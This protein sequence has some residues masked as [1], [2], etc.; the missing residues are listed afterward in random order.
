MS[1]AST[2][3]RAVLLGA[4]CAACTP[5]FV[6]ARTLESKTPGYVS[7]HADTRL[8]YFGKPGLNYCAEPMPDALREKTLR[9][10]A[11]R[12]HKG[13]V[14]IKA[15]D[16]AD[17]SVST[18]DAA[19]AELQTSLI[20]KELAG[21]DS[22]VL[23]SRELMYRL[24]ELNLN[25]SGKDDPSE[26]ELDRFNRTIDAYTKIAGA[27]AD[28]A[29]ADKAEAEATRALIDGSDTTIK[30]AAA[31][32]YVKI[33]GGR[34]DIIALLVKDNRGCTTEPVDTKL[35]DKA[36][37]KA[38]WK[39]SLDSLRVGSCKDLAEQLEHVSAEALPVIRDALR[40]AAEPAKKEEPA[41]KEE[42]AKEEP[43][44]T[45]PKDDKAAKDAK[46]PPNK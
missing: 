24:C 3:M 5:T 38:E 35:L 25:F 28:M 4:V 26:A 42:P 15:T 1:N 9:L 27:V 41:R 31:R 12:Q 19:K 43:R 22:T 8:A 32:A 23:I 13:S 18:D 6:P 17:V 46:K 37:V 30:Q 34:G 2:S 16:S 36:S 33:E 10:M 21:R 44:P 20:M 39:S 11:E 7:T 29:K 14:S 45:A 40:A